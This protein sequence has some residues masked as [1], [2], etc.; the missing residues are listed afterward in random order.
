ML[1]W[2]QTD[3]QDDANVIFAHLLKTYNQLI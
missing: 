2:L 1:L 3:R